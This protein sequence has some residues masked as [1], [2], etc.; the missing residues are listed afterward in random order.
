MGGRMRERAGKRPMELFIALGLALGGV[1]NLLG[2]TAPQSYAHVVPAGFLKLWAATNIVAGIC[3]F[4]G[5]LADEYRPWVIGNTALGFGLASYS[6]ALGHYSGRP[7]VSAVLIL[8]GAS[9]GFFASAWR[10]RR[11]QR[12]PPIDPAEYLDGLQRGY[13]G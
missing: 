5:V 7:S 12:L 9:L 13:H 6:V 10:L 8:S 1:F 4:S 2:F 3:T 11:I